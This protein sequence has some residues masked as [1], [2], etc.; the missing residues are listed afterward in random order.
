MGSRLDVSPSLLS[1]NSS[2]RSSRDSRKEMALSL[3]LILP[4]FPAASI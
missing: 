1:A 4:L 3:P 2:N